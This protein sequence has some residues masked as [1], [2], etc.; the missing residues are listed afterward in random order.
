[1]KVIKA[2]GEYKTNVC[3][4]ELLSRVGNYLIS[5][6]SFSVGKVIDCLRSVAKSLSTSF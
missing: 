1:M 3:L 6:D 4:G 5:S 2:V